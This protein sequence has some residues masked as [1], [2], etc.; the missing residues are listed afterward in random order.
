MHAIVDQG[1]KILELRYAPTF[2]AE[3]HPHLDFNTIHRAIVAGLVVPVTFAL[4]LNEV[5][6]RSFKRVVQTIVYLPH[7][8]S[9]VILSGILNEQ[10]DDVIEVY[11]QNGF[12]VVR[13]SVIVDWT[14]LVLGRK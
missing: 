9:W 7:F 13:R 5:R 11:Q 12:N 2:I 1:I 4:L 10:A 14:T 8:L 3:R 6:V